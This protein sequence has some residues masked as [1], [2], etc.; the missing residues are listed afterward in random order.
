[1]EETFLVSTDRNKLDIDMI[2]AY[3]SSQ[4]YWSKGR[5]R[6]VVEKSI[7]NS[8]CFGVYHPSGKQVGFARVVTDYA[9]FAWLMDVF[10]VEDY[11]GRGLSKQ[12][13]RSI[14]NHADLQNL[15]RWGLLTAD[16][17]ALYQ[18]YGFSS[19]DSPEWFMELVKSP[20]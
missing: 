8:L 5:S 13:L 14:M 11:R 4:A 20:S 17:H 3:L 1:M 6:S 9:V 19:V 7:A 10:I 16:A 18:Q 2:H 12:M 15:Q